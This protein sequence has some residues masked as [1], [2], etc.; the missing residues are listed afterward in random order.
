MIYLLE[1][2]L[3]LGLYS[4]LDLY[5]IAFREKELI[6]EEQSKYFQGNT[7]VAGVC[8]LVQHFITNWL[9]QI[10]KI[11]QNI[12]FYSASRPSSQVQNGRGLR[13]PV[14]R[15]ARSERQESTLIGLLAHARFL[16]K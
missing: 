15:D 11:Q 1:T 4:L 6:K 7:L 3:V 2:I 12:K 13:S 8:L 5:H 16:F 14:L 10:H 9:Y